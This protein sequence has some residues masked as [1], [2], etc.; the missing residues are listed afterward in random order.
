MVDAT[1]DVLADPAQRHDL[2]AEHADTP[3][4]AELDARL[5]RFFAANSDP[6]YDLWREGVSKGTPPMIF[7]DSRD[8]CLVI[9]RTR[10][11][12]LPFAA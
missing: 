3:L 6:R 9:W 2:Y 8:R 5:E 7:R 10:S 12:D 4:V 11:S 1:V